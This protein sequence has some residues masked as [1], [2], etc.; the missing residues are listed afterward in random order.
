MHTYFMFRVLKNYKNY[1]RSN[2]HQ[3]YCMTTI[4]VYV[5]IVGYPE[6]CEHAHPVRKFSVNVHAPFPSAKRM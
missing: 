1:K 6:E 2:V 5:I 3:T 4:N